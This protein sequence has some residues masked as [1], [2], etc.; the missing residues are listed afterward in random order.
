MVL[1]L[2]LQAAGN[3]S[4]AVVTAGHAVNGDQVLMGP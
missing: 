2:H 4:C 1:G 3:H